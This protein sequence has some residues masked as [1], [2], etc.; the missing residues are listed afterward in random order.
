MK[1]LSAELIGILTV[2]IALA[3]L[4]YS[5]Q[6]R[7]EGQL[8]AMDARMA[9]LEARMGSLEQRQARLEGLLEGMGI[10]G[11]TSSAE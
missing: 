2:G 11:R 10:A 9:A 1:R 5:G 3:G 8:A 7:A 6:A 4:V